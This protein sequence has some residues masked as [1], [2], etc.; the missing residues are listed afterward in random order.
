MSA[1]EQPFDEQTINLFDDNRK[2]ILQRLNMKLASLDLPDDEFHRCVK[3]FT[4]LEKQRVASQR[5]AA[6]VR[7]AELRA[8]SRITREEKPAGP[9][10]RPYQA[11]APWGTK[12]DGT[13]YTE[14]EF[15]KT[16]R[17]SVREIY[18]LNLPENYGRE[19]ET[20]RADPSSPSPSKGEGRGEGSNTSERPLT[21]SDPMTKEGRGEGQFS[22]NRHSPASPSG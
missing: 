21:V 19:R 10:A 20:N 9:R 7:V 22:S 14:D 12:A 13:P 11:D 17:R 4:E 5:I 16:L 6:A 15:Q 3:D 1:Q 8:E 2:L 18:G